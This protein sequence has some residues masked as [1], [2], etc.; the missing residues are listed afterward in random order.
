MG[1]RSIQILLEE[2]D[3]KTDRRIETLDGGMEPLLEAIAPGAL[4]PGWTGAGWRNLGRHPKGQALAFSLPSL[5]VK[6]AEG[7]AA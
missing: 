2:G 4:A 6:T 1:H 3:V 5:Q 7:E